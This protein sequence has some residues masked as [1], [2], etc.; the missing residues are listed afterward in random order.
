MKTEKI[1]IGEGSEYPLDGILTLPDSSAGPVPAVVLVHGSGSS[2]KDE[3]VGKLTPFKDLAEG[4]AVNGIASVRYDK[5]T[6]TYGRKMVK[7]GNITVY[8]ETIEDAVRAA[9]LLRKDERISHDNIFII[10]HSMGAMLAP[11]ID[12]EGGNFRGMILMAGTL[13]KLEDILIYQLKEI[14][15]ESG[16]LLKMLVDAQIRK[17]EE[18][19]RDLYTMPEE[20]TKKIKAGGGTTLYYFREM[21]DHPASSYLEKTEKPVLVMQGGKDVQVKKD[22]DYRDYQ[23]LLADR[24]NVT[25][26]LYD[27]L[28]HLFVP[29]LGYPISKLSKE[30][31]QEQHIPAG[32]VRDIADWIRSSLN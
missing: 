13:R 6:F 30:Y 32:V 27:D 28:N 16:F 23:N 19:F 7:E 21:G 26:R 17:N 9:D 2:D 3:K 5:R 22:I 25:F 14:S 31:A 12:A 24:D 10:G 11:R 4:L 18:L 8:K 29:S 15:G 1:I 20:D